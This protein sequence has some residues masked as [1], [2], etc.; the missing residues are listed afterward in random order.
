[1]FT[2]N[3]IFYLLIAASLIGLGIIVY[4]KI[5]V[6]SRLS[7][8]EMTILDR[9]KG[10]IE[11]IRE[12]DYKQH[13]LNF[14]IALE[15]FL[16]RTKIVFLKM[17]NL[18]SKCINYL[19]NRSQIMTQKSKEWIRQREMKR[20]KIKQDLP[21]ET[22]EKIPVKINRE[23]VDSQIREEEIE[24]EDELSISELKKP[25]K[26][27]QK[28]IDLIVEDPKNITAYKFLG[29][30]YWKQHNYSDAKASLEMAVKLGSKDKRVK[31]VLKELKKL[32]VK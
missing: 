11:K 23:E 26:E 29:L 7:E 15:K 6:L 24:D 10:I 30:L 14:I 22:K 5:P 12:A 8:D 3:S 9:K 4:R 25:I 18:L 19:R 21:T 13:W 32:R 31:E 28:W 20:R 17:E 2:L 27:E 1:M 16:R